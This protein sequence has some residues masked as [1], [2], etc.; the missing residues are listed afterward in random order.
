MKNLKFLFLFINFFLS[1]IGHAAFDAP[2]SINQECKQFVKSIEQTHNYGWLNVAETPANKNRISVFY[3][4][5]KTATLINSVLF[6]NGGPGLS[7]QNHFKSLEES[8]KKAITDK[9]SDIDFIFMDQRGTGCSSVFPLGIDDHTI[10]K[11]KWYG[12]AGIVRDAEVLRKTLIGQRQWKIF[13]QSFG[14]YVVH[15]YIEMHPEAI[16][17]AYVH[18]YAIGQSEFELSYARILNHGSPIFTP[19]ALTSLLRAT[20]HPSLFDRTTT[21]LPSSFG[22]NT[23]SHET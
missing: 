1:C 3:F 9:K 10:E 2:I 20:Q 14:G 12:S 15:R 19:R 11:L 13:G 17:K 5:S 23:R 4:Y 7:F 18:G 16:S 21:G 22:S 6:F 8:K